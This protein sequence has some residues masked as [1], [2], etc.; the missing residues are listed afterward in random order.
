MLS[1]VQVGL[2]VCSNKEKIHD[3][4]EISAFIIA[5]FW[6]EIWDG[7]SDLSQ[8]RGNRS[9]SDISNALRSPGGIPDCG[10]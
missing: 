4:D 6:R 7:G 3:F 2:S 10:E 5:R 8:C 9:A 1:A